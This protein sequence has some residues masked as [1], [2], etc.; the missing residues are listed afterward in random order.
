ERAA[1]A[2]LAASQP[3]AGH[4]FHGPGRRR[5]RAELLLDRSERHLFAAADQGVGTGELV[6]QRRRGV[7]LGEGALEPLAA[8]QLALGV[9]VSSRLVPEAAGD[10]D[11]RERA[12]GLCGRRA[13]RAASVPADPDAVDARPPPPGAARDQLPQRRVE[14]VR[15]AERARELVRGQKA[16]PGADRIHLERSLAAGDR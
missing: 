16:E 7:E 4:A 5:A 15:D 13:A 1:V 9:S 3:G 11:A 6:D 10:I 12:G 14:A 8:P 2:A